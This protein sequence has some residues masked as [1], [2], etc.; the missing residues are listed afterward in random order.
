MIF[1]AVAL[2]PSL[3]VHGY[4]EA[5]PYYSQAY[6]QAYYQSGYYSQATYGGVTFTTPVTALQG[7]TVTGSVG[8]GGGSFV[9]DHPLDAF[10]KLLFHSFVESPDVKNLYDGVAL[11]DNRGETVVQLPGYFE[12]LNKDFRYQLKPIGASMPDLYIKE[13]IKDNHFTIGGGVSG[14]KVSWQVTGIR[15][16][17][18]ILANPVIPEVNKGRD[19]LV[20][21]GEYVYPEGYKGTFSFGGFFS[22][23]WGILTG[24]F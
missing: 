15:H 24:W 18:Y 4:A 21:V 1:G 5:G 22:K 10:N 8:K 20:P 19:A 11:L 16:D 6:Y 14:G 12:A 7:I 23:L 3:H 13:E 17:A 9:I 2:F